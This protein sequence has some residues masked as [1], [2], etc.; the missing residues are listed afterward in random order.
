MLPHIIAGQVRHSGGKM[1]LGVL[2]ITELAPAPGPAEVQAVEVSDF[3]VAPVADDR[4]S[5]QGCRRMAFDA[6]QE[7]IEPLLEYARIGAL[8]AQG[9]DQGGREEVVSARFPRLAVAISAEPMNGTVANLTG[10]C[11]V[12]PIRPFQ[13]KDERERRVEM[14]PRADRVGEDLKVIAKAIRECSCERFQ[15]PA[16]ATLL[17]SHRFEMQIEQPGPAVRSL[18]TTAQR[19]VEIDEFGADLLRGE[20]LVRELRNLFV[21]IEPVQRQQRPPAMDTAMPVEASVEDRMKRAG[22]LC[23][24][25][26][27][28]NMVELVRIFLGHMPKS[29]LAHS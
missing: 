13:R 20:G 28:K 21:R 16:P 8:H 12:E 19:P 18:E 5:E 26:A 9:L 27:F 22:S 15:F 17:V 7:P 29:D 25:V 10:K 3:A 11:G 24:R 4:R 1:G 6:R 14:R 2:R 23:V